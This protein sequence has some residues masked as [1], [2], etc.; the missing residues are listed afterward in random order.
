MFHRCPKTLAI[1]A[2]IAVSSMAPAVEAE[3]E[4]APSMWVTGDAEL[5]AEVARTLRARGGAV[6][7]NGECGTVRADVARSNESVVVRITDVDGRTVERTAADPG[8]AATFIE[9]WAL[10]DL[11]DPLLAARYHKPGVQMGDADKPHDIPEPPPLEVETANKPIP[12]QTSRLDLDV[13]FDFGFGSETSIWTAVRVSG[14]VMFHDVCVGALVR[15]AQDTHVSGDGADLGTEREFLE[16]LLTFE[17][18]IERGAIDYKPG[19]GIGQAAYDG[20][21]RAEEIEEE[22]RGLRLQAHT[23]M[24]YA[25]RGNWRVQAN[26][27]VGYATFLKDH[28]DTAA[29]PLAGIPPLE[30]W[31]G[32]GIGYGGW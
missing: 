22:E 16:T 26:A 23:T 32:V 5:A 14:C 30:L 17:I 12:A 20:E 3:P 7:D 8:A 10:H 15:Y 13:G 9:S 25:L 31:L 24:N 19:I 11:T 2:A 1:V 29:G 27:A 21:I 28:Y 18:P 6:S 4:C